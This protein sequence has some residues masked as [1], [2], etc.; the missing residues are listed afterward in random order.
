MS[1]AG[2]HLRAVRTITGPHQRV[3]Q[4]FQ[5]MPTATDEDW[6]TVARRMARVPQAFD[7]WHG[8]LAEGARRGLHA[9]PRQLRPS[10]PSS[11]SGSTPGVHGF[12]AFAIS[13]APDG[14]ALRR[15]HRAAHAAD[16]AAAALRTF[17]LDD[18]RPRP[19]ARRTPSAG[20]ATPRRAAGPAPTS[21]CMRP[22]PGAG[23]SPPARPGDSAEADKVLPGATPM[24]AMR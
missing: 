23:R 11:T 2:E 19:K 15:P 14:S 18:Y 21:T 20:S 7:S 9:A 8:A 12:V 17:L 1:A 13:A 5:L 3:R 22:T 10:S 16:E 6:A 4:L 24:E